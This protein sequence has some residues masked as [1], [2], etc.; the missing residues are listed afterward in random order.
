MEI[1]Y[2]E[3][4]S[5]TSADGLSRWPIDNFQSNPA[6]DP[7]MATKIPI[8][9]MEIDRRKNFIFSELAPEFAASDS[10]STEPE[11]KQPPI[12]GIC[13]SELHN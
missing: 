13:S 3:G 4:T 12:S 5:L 2:K 6:Y 11:G 7:E 1:I 10:D 8:H 9:F